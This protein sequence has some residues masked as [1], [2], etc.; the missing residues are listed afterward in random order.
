[1]NYML[2]WRT[3]QANKDDNQFSQRFLLR[4]LLRKA[5]PDQSQLQPV[6]KGLRTM[7]DSPGIDLYSQ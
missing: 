1:M 7:Q 5:L 4:V 6:I 3:I 2:Y